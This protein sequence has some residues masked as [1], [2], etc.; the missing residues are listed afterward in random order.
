LH[1]GSDGAGETLPDG[2][3]D[4]LLRVEPDNLAKIIG[5]CVT[6]ASDYVLKLPLIS[7]RGVESDPEKDE[8]RVWVI[9]RGFCST[10]PTNGTMHAQPHRFRKILSDASLFFF[11]SRIKLT[12]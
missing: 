9:G 10:Y 12:G 1:E 5:E 2:I 7:I 4:A 11:Q 8:R 6:L 3:V